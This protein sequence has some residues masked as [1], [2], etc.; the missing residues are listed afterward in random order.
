MSDHT[1]YFG[2][3]GKIYASI[4]ASGQEVDMQALLNDGDALLAWARDEANETKEYKPAQNGSQPASTQP[5]GPLKT[6]ISVN[7]V[8]VVKEGQHDDGKA[9]KL[10]NVL[11]EDGTKYSTFAGARFMVGET[12]SIEYSQKQN[13]KYLNLIINDKVKP[14]L[15]EADTEGDGDLPF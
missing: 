7:E 15:I 9:W 11:D 8:K 3:M 12:Y 14:V 1:F 10:Y 4:R 13:G 2:T 5:I 6:R